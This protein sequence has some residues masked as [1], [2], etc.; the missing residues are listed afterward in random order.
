[1]RSRL[2]VPIALLSL[3]ACSHV[4]PMAQPAPQPGVDTVSYSRAPDVLAD[5]GDNTPRTYR[6]VF[7]SGFE[8]SWFQPCN[9]TPGDAMWWVT[10]TD[11]AL[12]QRDSLLGRLT[13]APSN[14]LVF[15]WV[16]TISPKM[17]MG[18]GHGGRGSRYMLVTRVL[19]VHAADADEQVSCGSP[20]RFG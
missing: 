18:A 12:A 10:F 13:T 7:S 16:G 11:E 6:G 8:V 20:N 19:G 5:A 1:M 2:L 9:A 14:G 15:E 4:T 3:A 17:A